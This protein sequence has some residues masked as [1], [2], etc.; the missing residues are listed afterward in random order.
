MA[1][2]NYF[3][4]VVKRMREILEAS[5]DLGKSRAFCFGSRQSKRRSSWLRCS[6]SIRQNASSAAKSGLIATAAFVPQGHNM[7][8]L[9][10]AAV[11][12]IPDAF[13]LY[14]W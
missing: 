5:H 14:G 11:A 2:I 13:L 3:R 9:A 8:A 10:A 7:T 12:S 4:G 1:I 6:A